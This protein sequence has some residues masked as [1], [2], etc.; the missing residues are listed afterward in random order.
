MICMV[1]G[2]FPTLIVLKTFHLFKSL[3]KFHI[4]AYAFK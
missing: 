4:G 1:D 2:S 3:V